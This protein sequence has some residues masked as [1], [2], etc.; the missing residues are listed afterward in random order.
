MKARTAWLLHVTQGSALLAGLVTVAAWVKDVQALELVKLGGA[1]FAGAV[2]L[3][4][5]MVQFATGPEKR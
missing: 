3:G 5:C 4:I 2:L 1:T